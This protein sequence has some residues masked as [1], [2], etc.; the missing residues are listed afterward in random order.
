MNDNATATIIGAV[1]G[2]IIGS[3]LTIAYSRALRWH[4]AA[5]RK[6]QI[7]F[8]LRQLQ[9]HMGMIRDFPTY[10]YYDVASLTAKLSELTLEA[11]SASG[12]S[13]RE[14]ESVFLA[15]YQADQEAS[16]LNADRDKMLR[17]N[18]TEYIRAAGVRAFAQIHKARECLNDVGVL[19]RP[20]DP[21]TLHTWKSGEQIQGSAVP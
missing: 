10:Y 13:T 19:V 2:G 16:F 5:G 11:L 3:S 7:V 1:L 6:G 20:S 12:L 14:R 15:V 18:E 17:N 9:I 8:L 4:D 21:R